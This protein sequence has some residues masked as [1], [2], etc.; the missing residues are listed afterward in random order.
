MV[1]DGVSGM[2]LTWVQ[3]DADKINIKIDDGTG[4][5]PWKIEKTPNDGHEFLPNVFS[6]QNIMIKPTNHCKEGEYSLAV[7][8]LAYPYGWY[9]Q[10]ENKVALASNTLGYSTKSALYWELLL[11]Q[12]K[13]HQKKPQWYLKQV[14]V[15]F[16]I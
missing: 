16:C 4:K 5:Y 14:V 6:W 8:Q 2:N 1:K 9:G 11:N 3:Y 7:N 15:I 12:K 10:S 13:L